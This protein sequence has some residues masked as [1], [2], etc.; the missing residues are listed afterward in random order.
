MKYDEDDGKHDQDVHPIAG[1][2]KIRT[3]PSSKSAK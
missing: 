3:D 1:F 2:W